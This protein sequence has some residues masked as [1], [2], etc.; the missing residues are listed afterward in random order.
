M[1]VVC[2]DLFLMKF[3]F[4]M[5]SGQNSSVKFDTCINVLIPSNNTLFYYSAQPFIC[6]KYIVVPACLIPR[7]SK[8]F[9]N[10]LLQ[11]SNLLPDLKVLIFFS[12]SLYHSYKIFQFVINLIFVM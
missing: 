10:G 4:I 5:A 12:V 3:T 1:C 9:Y 11:Y 7:L 8:T 2:N 6:S